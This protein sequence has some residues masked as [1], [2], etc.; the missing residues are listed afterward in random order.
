M[1]LCLGCVVFFGR[2][3]PQKANI[4][5]VLSE[6]HNL[7][8]GAPRVKHERDFDEIRRFPGIDFSYGHKHSG[9]P[10]T[11]FSSTN[12]HNERVEH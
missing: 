12:K 9:E 5:I 8:N 4:L 1:C 6:T 10:A 2:E 3:K 7:H 11:N